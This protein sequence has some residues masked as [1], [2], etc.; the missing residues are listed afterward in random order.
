MKRAGRGRMEKL[1]VSDGEDGETVRESTSLSSK[2]EQK[3]WLPL[4]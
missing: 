3:L 4:A 2:A 1:D